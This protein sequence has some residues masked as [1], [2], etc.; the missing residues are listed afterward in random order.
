MR[1][2]DVD[3]IFRRLEEPLE[4][5]DVV[6]IMGYHVNTLQTEFAGMLDEGFLKDRLVRRVMRPDTFEMLLDLALSENDGCVREKSLL[7]RRCEAFRENVARVFFVTVALAKQ[8][9]QGGP[10]ES[11]I[12]SRGDDVMAVVQHAALYSGEAFIHAPEAMTATL[13]QAAETVRKLLV[14]P[15]PAAYFESSADPDTRAEL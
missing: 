7:T 11:V 1:A 3:L 6:S 2:A 5:A 8:Y 9:V 14:S 10:L 15:A 4:R 12:D 13:R